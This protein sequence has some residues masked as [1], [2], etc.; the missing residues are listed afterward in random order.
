MCLQQAAVSARRTLSTR[1]VHHRPPDRRSRGI[2]NRT[3]MMQI[4]CIPCGPRDE[5]EFACGG[6]SHLRGRRGGERPSLGRRSVLSRQSQGPACRTLAPRAGLRPVVQSRAQYGH[7]RHTLRVLHHRSAPRMTASRLSAPLGTRL[8][9]S[10]R[11][12]FQFKRPHLKWPSRRHPGLGAV[13]E[14]SRS[15][16]AQFS[17]CTG[18]AAFSLCGVEE[19][20]GL[21][22]LSVGATRTPNM[23][24]TLVELYEGFVA[25]S[26]QLLAQRRIR[27]G[28]RQQQVAALLP[29][30]VLTTR[31][32][33]GPTGICSNPRF[34]AWRGLGRASGSPIRIVTKKRRRR[35]TCWSSAAGLQA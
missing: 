22:D 24:A 11:L 18:R 17:S 29:G 1:P 26:R 33:S 12:S 9:R 30:G 8:D 5:S 34:A 21:V 20:T 32:S 6:T 28:R 10:Q 23:R 25:A 7:P 3:L 35:R 2:G 13:G 19:P 27:S 16:G 15:R 14:R 4:P 31:P